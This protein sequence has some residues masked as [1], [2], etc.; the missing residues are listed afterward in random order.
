MNAATDEN[1]TSTREGHRTVIHGPDAVHDNLCRL[2][3]GAE[4][5]IQV[6]GPLLEPML[7]STAR[8]TDAITAFLARNR[9]NRIELL[10]EDSRQ[11]LRD[12]ARLVGLLQKLS[13]YAELRELGEEDRGQRD[14]FVCIDRRSYLHQPD[15]SRPECMVADDNRD[16]AMML[17]NRFSDC[18]HR[19][20][21]VALS[22]TLGL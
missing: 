14:L 8:L 22:R 20:A 11:V 12:D 9:R 17:A 10:V 18:W 2:I 21:P 3:A 6:Y 13:D 1:A 7:F 16:I 4:S 19:A 15:I 5:Q